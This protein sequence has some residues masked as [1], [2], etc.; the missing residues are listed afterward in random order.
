M[1]HREAKK[2]V[3]GHTVH[4]LQNSDL[5]PGFLTPK[6]GCLGNLVLTT[7]TIIITDVQTPNQEIQTQEV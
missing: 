3:Q 2:L 6:P 4:Y 5:T 7:T 1:R